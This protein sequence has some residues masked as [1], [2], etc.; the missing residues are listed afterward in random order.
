MEGRTV[1]MH[2]SEAV[3]RDAATFRPLSPVSRR[4]HPPS[5]ER[6]RTVDSPILM[7]ISLRWP[8][9]EYATCLS[10]KYRNRPSLNNQKS[11]PSL[12]RGTG[13]AIYL[14]LKPKHQSRYNQYP[15]RR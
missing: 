10:P 9:G 3:P 6:I 11:R 2:R 14:R 1:R 8:T 5:A 13:Q 12:N 15:A 4:A 7:P